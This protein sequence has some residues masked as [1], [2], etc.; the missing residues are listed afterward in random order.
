MNTIRIAWGSDSILVVE[1]LAIRAFLKVLEFDEAVPP[2]EIPLELTPGLMHDPETLSTPYAKLAPLPSQRCDLARQLFQRSLGLE[3]PAVLQLR[4][5]NGGV[6]DL[7]VVRASF[8]RDEP[9]SMTIHV[10]LDGY[11]IEKASG[12]SFRQERV[13]REDV[14]EIHYRHIDASF[15][16]VRPKVTDH[17]NVPNRE[18]YW[19]LVPLLSA[20]DQPR[21]YKRTELQLESI[22]PRLLHQA[23]SFMYQRNAFSA[24]ELSYALGVPERQAAEFWKT[25]VA[26]GIVVRE[27]S[28]WQLNPGSERDIVRRQTGRLSRK[29]A[30]AL[31]E[32][33]ADNAKA[34]NALPD[35]ESAI[36]VTEL[37]VLGAYLNIRQDDFDALYVA[38]AAEVRES[39]KWPYL[40]DL[41]DPR[42]GFSAIEKRLQV[43]DRRVRLLPATAAHQFDCPQARF[44]RFEAP[45][46]ATA[47]LSAAA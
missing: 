6:E 32:E 16:R 22:V 26:E 4:Y 36:Y 1:P 9:D 7:L 19:P 41:D 12:I 17:W 46:I 2:P 11:G 14:A 31:I 24:R 18:A 33:L 37:T 15:V 8:Q 29:E 21:K 47:R 35:G 20:K 28:V 3:L 38:W 34:I 45:A 30:A 27:G 10:R 25:L 13:L 39:P 43:K 40:P 42:T 23:L 44:Y 5:K